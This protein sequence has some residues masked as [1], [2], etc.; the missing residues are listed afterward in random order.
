MTAEKRI[1]KSLSLPQS[2]RLVCKLLCGTIEFYDLCDD[3]PGRPEWMDESWE[4]LGPGV[5]HSINGIPQ[6]SQIVRY[7]W[8][9]TGN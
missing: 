3:N 8:R 4:S 7:F 5:I 9:K 6:N 2:G 1:L